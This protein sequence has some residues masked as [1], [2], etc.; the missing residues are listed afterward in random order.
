MTDA[1]PWDQLLDYDPD[2]VDPDVPFTLELLDGTEVRAYAQGEHFVAELP[3][4]VTDDGRLVIGNA[5]GR[6]P[7][8]D[9]IAGIGRPVERTGRL[10][11]VRSLF[12]RSAALR[13][14][15]RDAERRAEEDTDA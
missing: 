3:V 14:K 11:I 1:G 12:H 13:R 2:R 15:Q 9:D 7:Q 8:G 10:V 4:D 6:R 5:P